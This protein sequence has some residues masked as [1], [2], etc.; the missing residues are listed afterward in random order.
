MFAC[1]VA[2][3]CAS[4]NLPRLRPHRL[5]A[6]GERYDS[7]SAAVGGVHG[8]KY[9]FGSTS[10]DGESFASALASA[11]AA[12]S[13][14]DTRDDSDEPW[15]AW[16]TALL[17]PS[18]LE[19][20]TVIID[21]AVA[22]A[23]VTISNQLRSWEPWYASFVWPPEAGSGKLGAPPMAEAFE[24]SPS[25]GTLAPRG[26]ANNVCDPSKPYSDEAQLTIRW[27]CGGAPQQL[28]SSARLLVRTEE[29]QWLFGVET[30]G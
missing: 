17:R 3:R 1:A 2:L 28:P 15:P 7:L 29:D 25:K 30:R 12:S 27:R 11:T 16:A 5:Q 14:H 19:E 23:C 21:A 9:Q 22:E 18:Q 26:G 10:Y 13:E 24:A 4:C 6:D 20:E 8:G